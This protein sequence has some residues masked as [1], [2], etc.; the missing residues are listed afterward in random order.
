MHEGPARPVSE[1]RTANMAMPLAS[2]WTIEPVDVGK[3]FDP[4]GDRSLVLD[5]G[6]HPHIAYGGK[7]LYYAW[8]DGMAWHIEVVDPGYKVGRFTSLALDS[9]GHPHIA[10]RDDTNGA[11]K[12]A[13]FDGVSWQIETLDTTGFVWWGNSAA[14]AL[15]AADHPHI[16]YYDAANGDLKYA[17][18]DGTTWFTETVDSTGNVGRWASLAVDAAGRPHVSYHDDTNNTLKY[19]YL[20]PTGWIST[21][22]EAQGGEFTSLALDQAGR[23]HISHL[24][25][26]MYA[27]RYAYFDGTAWFS[28][29]VD[30]AQGSVY[31]SI[32]LDGNNQPRI[33]YY[34]ADIDYLQY[35]YRESGSWQIQVVDFAGG[36]G[37]SL[38]LD[39]AGLPYISYLEGGYCYFY[40]TCG[41]LLASNHGAGWEIQT[42]DRPGRT[43][44][45]AS[46]ALDPAG[47]P[48]ISYISSTAYLGA[49]MKYATW[50][51][52]AWQ[53]EVV[54]SEGN[55]FTSLALDANGFPRISYSAGPSRTLRYASFN[56]TDWITETVDSTWWSGFYTSLA[57]D[58][59]GHP[60]IGYFG[61]YHVRYAYND[62]TG[63][64]TTTVE[65]APGDESGY[66]SLA[67]DAA[68]RPH[69]TYIVYDFSTY[70]C[71]LRYAYYSGTN[72]ITTTVDI[73]QEG[74]TSLVLD[75]DGH[76]HISYSKS[77]DRL[78][79]AYYDGMTWHIEVVDNVPTGWSGL[80]LDW[81]G[82]PHIAYYDYD[83]LY[84]AFYDYQVWQTE[85][86]D[87]DIGYYT[88]GLPATPLALDAQGLPHISYYDATNGD[89]KYARI[90]ECV[91]VTG[92][93]IFG[94]DHTPAGITSLYT[95]TFAPPSA[96]LPLLT[97]DNGTIGPMA[98]Y[99]WTVPGMYTITLTATNGCGQVQAVFP[100]T[101]FCQAVEGVTISGPPV[102]PAGVEG[103]YLAA[104]LPI[105]ASPPITFTWDNGTLGS[106]AVYS[107]TE[108]GTHTLA[109]SA[110]NRCGLA[111]GFYNVFVPCS[112]VLNADFTW[113]PL[114]PTAGQPV[115]FTAT[116]GS[117]DS[118]WLSTTVASVGEWFDRNVSLAL[119]PADHPHLCYYDAIQGDLIYAYSLDGLTWYTETVDAGDA[120]MDCSL[121][122]DSA[123]RPH[124]SYQSLEGADYLLKY[125]YYD[126]HSWQ[127]EVVDSQGGT[128]SFTSLAL[129]GQGLPHIG[130]ARV[131]FMTGEL[132]YAWHDGNTWHIEIIDPITFPPI[133]YFISLRLSA[134]GSPKIAYG[135]WWD[136][137]TLKY[138][139]YVGGGG[140]CGPSGGWQCETLGSG[141]D[142]SLALDENDQPHF[143]Y[144]TNCPN[145]ALVY[146][147]DPVDAIGGGW[148]DRSGTSLAMDPLGQPH[149]AY[150][151]AT[152]AN[153]RYAR[154]NLTAWFTET[155]ATAGD[156]GRYASLALDA[157]GQ[158]H[159][160]YYDLTNHELHY[161]WQRAGATQPVTYTWNLG[162]GSLA[163]GETIS[164][165]YTVPGSYNVVLT[166]TNC[167]GNGL[168]TAV[169][170]VA[171]EGSCTP[172]YDLDFTWTP[173]TPTAG[174]AV[175]FTASASGTRPLS[176]S[177][178][179]GD[180]TYGAGM[181]LTHIYSAPGTYTVGLTVTN[182][183]T[184]T[185]SLTRT[186][187]VVSSC[188]P[189]HHLDF[190]WQPLTPTAGQAVTFTASASGSV[191]MA[192]LWS[193]GDGVTAEGPT[194]THIYAQ[195]ETYGVFVTATNA[196]G[197]ATLGQ[198][199]MVKPPI[200]RVYLPLVMH[201]W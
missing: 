158:P 112:P 184:A 146:D 47:H 169:H 194:V 88:W 51:G 35:A 152:N 77:N 200:W 102:L 179:L 67:L 139:Y 71:D 2:N 41:L 130:Y 171:V 22:V 13:H 26:G 142:V 46:L 12:Y 87:T 33:A 99:S 16:A 48:H 196:C 85:V 134:S 168:A 105:T 64:V 37:A 124:I 79:Y 97:W 164:H 86:V 175:T 82:R 14:L 78:G 49:V 182:C 8:H 119:D 160:A 150:Y 83:N 95:A 69:I 140:N 201:R 6:N 156:V 183:A 57:L 191:P 90:A 1:R 23:P 165:T 56:G 186:L 91:P 189:V 60:H 157:T 161:V 58:S 121:A 123:G 185:A 151:D 111:Y 70:H 116:A 174:Q 181:T 7:N 54:D 81:A 42:V 53:T 30:Y 107:W 108:P 34:R 136:Y 25:S 129:D 89:L 74:A 149:I 9:A 3:Q 118:G 101:V 66:I 100:V 55:G 62:G 138:A 50:D 20:T 127:T 154:Y 80:A 75:S 92:A 153:L 11:L 155:V 163:E 65:A 131:G 190:A 93:S 147:G 172:A 103:T 198:T 68:G 188:E 32:A 133:Q 45:F 195:P 38:A 109:V 18:F 44:S 19:A 193:F 128:G 125:A 15:D 5:A 159:I 180:G 59:A 143:S 135:R 117:G 4:V 98:H 39:S 199:V 187:T 126:G 167:Q 170:T 113:H 72:W 63:W 24:S 114:T 173:L 40:G 148:H 43:G 115:F 17:Y 176:F 197:Q 28:E 61:N 73:A 120:G 31:T 76:P 178:D 29:T 177:W 96:T 162:D 137:F 21:T 145:C 36:R 104:S 192:F 132:R 27:M 106:T 94:R 144:R 84:Y 141:V 110:T 10:Y 52:L 166:A 122:L